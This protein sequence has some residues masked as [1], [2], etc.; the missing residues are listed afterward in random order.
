MRW[1]VPWFM[2]VFAILTL[3]L[4]SRGSIYQA[5]LIAQ[6]LFYGIALVGWLSMRAREYSVVRI[7]FFFVQTN[8]ALAKALSSFLMGNRMT[9]WT[10]S[11]R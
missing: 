11:R 4:Q 7:I 6:L 5:A 3:L 1:A 10:P 8:L 9:V 2:L